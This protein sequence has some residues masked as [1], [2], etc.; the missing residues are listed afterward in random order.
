MLNLRIYLF[1]AQRQRVAAG[2]K[3]EAEKIIQVKRA[4]AEAETKYLSGVGVARQ[5]E[6]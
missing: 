2:D 5:R 3:A 1:P 6:V 4:E